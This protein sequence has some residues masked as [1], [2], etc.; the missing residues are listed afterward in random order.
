VPHPPWNRRFA[1]STRGRIVALLRRG[2]R[3]V[4]ELAQQIGLTDNAVRAQ[5]ATLERDGL[6]RQRGTVKGAGKPAYAY[7]LAPD[8]EP[9]LSRA[10]LPIFDA[11]MAALEVRL[12]PEELRQTL[13]EAGRRA[14]D[15]G[16]ALGGDVAARARG[17]AA[18][19]NELGGLAEAVTP[20]GVSW[21]IVSEGCPL[22][23]LVPGHPALCRAVEAM[24]ATM[25]ATEVRERCRR[26]GERPAC[27]F[28]L[29]AGEETAPAE[30]GS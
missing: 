25:T 6:V 30:R 17:A 23:A 24:L 22:S 1:E 16:P 10:Y 28:E 27:R 11:L 2:T 7:E 20:D 19:L 3:T 21:A 5:L 29:G 8:V 13:Q 12:A 14:A 9:A 4:D 26:D 18:V 15:A